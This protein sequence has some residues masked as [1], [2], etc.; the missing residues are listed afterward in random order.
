MPSGEV[1][2]DRIVRMRFDNKDFD[3]NIQKSQKT[4]EDFKKELN[5]DDAVRQMQGFAETSKILT[6]MSDNIRKLSDH[7]AGIGTLSEYI[8]G[9]VKQAWHG[10]LNSVE[11]FTKS[12]TVVQKQAG[13][14][15]YDG[16]LKA[17]QTIKS[18]TGDTEDFVYAQM[19]LL[20]DYTD[21]TSYDFADMAQ[22]IGKFTTAGIG[23]KEAREEMQGIANWAA[24]AGQGV[25]EAQ[26]AMYNISQ[27]IS[28]GAMRLQDWKSI[29]NA[30]MDT[31]RFRTEALKAA[32]AVGTLVEKGDKLYTKKGNKLVNEDNF[33]ET[34]QFKWFDKATMEEVFKVFSD[35]SKGIGKEAYAAAQRCV[36][37]KD[38]LNAIKDMLSTGWM[39]TYEH[40]FGRLSDA[41]N[42][43]SGLCNKAGAEL[44]KFV[45][46]RNGI[47]EHWSV[48]GGRDSLWAALVGELD[49][50]DAGTLYSGAF[51][52]LD[53]LTGVGDLIEK[54]FRAFVRNFVSSI[55]LEKF[56]NDP[57]YM[58][59]YLGG[60]LVTFTG[61]VQ[62]FVNGIK[63]FF[64]E[65]PPGMT[66]SRFTQIQHVVEAV[67]ATTMLVVSV[68]SGLSQF[69]FE[70]MTQLQPASDALLHLISY[71]SQLFTGKVVQATKKNTVGNWFHQLAE[72]LRPITGIINNAVGIVVSLLEKFLGWASKTGALDA[73][74]KSIVWVTD[75]ISKFAGAILNF[76]TIIPLLSDIK[77][78]DGFSNL[79]QKIKDA[80]KQTKIFQKVWPRLSKYISGEK[81]DEAI[82]SVKNFF[83]ELGEKLPEKIEHIKTKIA[84]GFAAGGNLFESIIGALLGLVSSDAVAEEF[85]DTVTEAVVDAVTPASGDESVV[86][87]VSSK[88]IGIFSK[89]KDFFSTLFNE[90][91]PSIF[92]NEAI[93]KVKDFITKTDWSQFYD[94]VINVMKLWSSI[95]WAGGVA[96]MGKGI[97]NIGKGM[98]G[99]GKGIKA[100]SKAFGKMD[101]STM[102]KNMVNFDHAFNTNTTV[103]NIT[104]SF[105]GFGAQLLMIAGSVYL[106]VEALNKL[107]GTKLE[108]LKDPAI[109]LVSILGILLTASLIAAKFAG[110]G[111]GFIAIAGAVYIITTMLSGMVVMPWT[112]FFT[113]VTKLMI[114]CGLLA[115]TAQASGSVKL[116]GFI[117][118]AISV[119]ILTAVVRE[120]GRMD[121][122][123][124]WSG[125]SRL[126][127]IFLM[128]AGLSFVAGKFKPNGFKGMIG[129]AVAIGLLLI[130]I[131]VL[132]KMDLGQYAQG[133]IGLL[134]IIGAIGAFLYANK[135]TEKASKVAGLVGAIAALAFMA[136]LIGNMPVQNAVVGFG[137][138]VAL[139][140]SL[141][142]LL[143]QAGKMREKQM[144]KLTVVMGM[145]IG[146]VA[147]IAAAMGVLHALKVPWEFVA[148]FLGGI[149]A[150]IAVVGLLFP[151]IAKI[152][153]AGAVKAIAILAAIILALAAVFKLVAPMVM[154]SFGEGLEKMFSKLS[155]T[156]GNIQ[157]FVSSITGISSGSIDDVKT[158]ITSLYE[159]IKTLAGFSEMRAAID[160]FSVQMNNLRAGISGLFYGDSNIPSFVGSNVYSALVG[161]RDLM[162]TLR[163]IEIGTLPR[164]LV[165]LGAGLSLF[166]DSTKD[167]G[168]PEDNVGVKFLNQIFKQAENIRTINT[169][170]LGGLADKMTTLGGA[171]KIYASAATG[172]KDVDSPADPEK[173]KAAV[174]IFNAIATSLAGDGENGGFKIPENMP[175]Q[176]QI[177]TFGAELAA[178]GVA[179]SQFIE[180]CSGFNTDTD[181][182]IN[183]LKVIGELNTNLTAD[184]LEVTKV[185]D[186]ADVDDLTLADFATCIGALGEALSKFSSLTVGGDFSTGLYALDQLGELNHRLSTDVID[187]FTVLPDNQI[188]DS[189]LAIFARDIEALGRALAVFGEQVN[190]VND[191]GEIDQ[192]K[193]TNFNNALDGVSQLANV[194]TNMPKIGGLVEV[195]AGHSKGLDELGTEIED[196]AVSLVTFSQHLNNLPTSN[197]P[198]AQGNGAGFEYTDKVK[199]ALSVL[200]ELVKIRGEVAKEKIEGL[201]QLIRG[202]A[203]SLGDLGEDITELGEGL[204]S[205]STALNG[206]DG[207]QGFD[208]DKVLGALTAV[209]I[210]IDSANQLKA[211]NPESGDLLGAY[212]Y[213]H[214]LSDFVQY[215]TDDFFGGDT[216]NFATRLLTFS[217]KLTDAFNKTGGIDVSVLGA[218]GSLVSG[219]TNM[220]SGFTS[221]IFT[222]PGVTIANGIAQGITSGHDTVMAA[223]TQLAADI[224]EAF[225]TSI[226]S[227][228]VSPVLD[229]QKLEADIA[230]LQI[231]TLNAPVTGTIDVYVTNPVDLSGVISSISAVESQ[232]AALGTAISNMQIVLNTNVLAGNLAGPIDQNFS[233]RGLYAARRNSGSNGP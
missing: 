36:T 119:G 8:A 60:L 89:I 104:K 80:I 91:I 4:L 131:K 132:G 224:N 121:E 180:S 209:N 128:L 105:G 173:I 201:E 130:P 37:F 123:V 14:E 162:P 210:L 151:L 71:V 109:V 142:F 95:K 39:K 49:T 216:D 16:L 66:E 107:R 117:G 38:A 68:I 116:K 164:K 166:S 48:T 73:I 86:E 226:T 110:G 215:L 82:A 198:D 53:M 183:A 217:Q 93:T 196:L 76:D 58:F 230:N 181:F 24:L 69:G 120:L 208:L 30:S 61:N 176:G 85:S 233:R 136:F 52:L 106:V 9:K 213:V 197:M 204:L 63:S 122:G 168:S 227:P 154:E 150:L 112:D 167:L 98:K 165:L 113:A 149:V 18:A 202:H 46:I 99:L 10:A 134:L 118:L 125:I 157:S 127:P 17:V 87:K 15:K 40:I 5:F 114:L 29:Q 160:S 205:F 190:F 137:A 138:I 20:N 188:T 45:D 185:F 101:F 44:Q 222:E 140:A 67:Y 129:L 218:F 214:T 88:Y 172:I 115:M 59:S 103:T 170:N 203:T 55:N 199:N 70:L 32:V 96:S 12:L 90:T 229:T 57:E 77:L 19:K 192:A 191:K 43:F 147:I 84:E 223:V 50:P 108:E 232:V 159:T 153:I 206:V 145:V 152:E 220:A 193:V 187:V 1:M 65:I 81:F 6:S 182:A 178:L 156:G 221:D 28:A 54:G 41:I 148:S 144:T 75:K 51:G 189:T 143:Q 225:K 179:M 64:T 139:M 74:G 21:E 23:L 31:R 228:T 155:K 42:V 171:L 22:N 78:S 141:G 7:F 27:A 175:D 124:A 219:L 34:L 79:G 13:S 83:T 72:S 169:L 2:D 174:D 211:L 163:G 158:K 62:K 111:L 47:L 33:T 3:K 133:I 207:S 161:I 26:R 195:F 97:G 177:S 135:D 102:F 231:A 184:K 126:F 11:S 35:N 146:L 186:R 100:M 92:Q 200:Q 25:G 56:D 194:A 212:N 94:K